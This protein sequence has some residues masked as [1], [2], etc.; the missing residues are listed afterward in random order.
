MSSVLINVLT[1]ALKKTSKSVL[2]ISRATSH[3]SAKKKLRGRYANPYR[4][5]S[6]PR[7]L[8]LSQ[9]TA[10]PSFLIKILQEVSLEKVGD[11]KGRQPVAKTGVSIWLTK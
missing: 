6:A 8:Q 5:C 9:P 11:V 1:Q 7:V 2:T 3:V 10:A 4:L